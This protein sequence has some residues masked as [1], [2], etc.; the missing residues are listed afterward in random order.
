LAAWAIHWFATARAS[1]ATARKN[2]R[3]LN[4]ARVDKK[5]A[6]SFRGPRGEHLQ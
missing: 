1:L 3:R 4:V 5:P 2:L 6:A